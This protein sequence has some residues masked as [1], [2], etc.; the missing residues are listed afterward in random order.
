MRNQNIV[1]GKWKII[2][3]IQKNLQSKEKYIF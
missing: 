2:F 3:G 1:E